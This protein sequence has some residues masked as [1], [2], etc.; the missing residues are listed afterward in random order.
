[1]A[2][3]IYITLSVIFLISLQSMAQKDYQA[4]V[5][6]AL[7]YTEGQNFVAAE[8]AYKA[9]MREE[10]AN[11]GNIMLMMNLGTVQRYLEKF[12]EALI[13]Y[14]VV[15]QKYPNLPYLLENRARLYCDMDRLDDALK[16]YTAI[17]MTNPDNLDVLYDRGL[18]YIALQKL[19]E[20]EGDFKNMLSVD[21]KNVMAKSG[22]GM[23]M[24]RRGEWKGAEQL[25][26]DLIA[27]DKLNG[28]LYAYRAECYLDMKRLRS[29]EDDLD[30]A[31]QYGYNDYLIN[32]L[33]GQLK[34]AQYDKLAAREEFK[35]ALEMGAKEELVNDFL[36]LCK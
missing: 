3:K 33:R 16:D 24:K 11:P 21:Q 23:V 29:M 1:M 25:Y 15:L 34:L 7:D 2:K 18:V 8:Q 26:S 31:S 36:L 19:D 30:K 14:N 32:I 6:D 20:A 10:P 13:S 22:L 35:K 17:L 9:A 12:D 27:E 28:V 4:Y 5:Q